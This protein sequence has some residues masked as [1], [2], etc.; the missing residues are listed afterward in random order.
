MVEFILRHFR[1]HSL[2]ASREIHMKI[3][4]ERIP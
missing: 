1:T 3:Y 4:H 2:G